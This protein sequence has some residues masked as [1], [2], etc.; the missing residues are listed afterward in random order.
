[1][2]HR[3]FVVVIDALGVGALPDT[4]VYGDRLTDNTLATLDAQAENFSI[5]LLAQLGLGH[6]QPFQRIPAA[7]HPI[8]QYGKLAEQSLGKD[9]TTGHWEMMGHITRI[10]FPTYPNGFPPEIID[11]FIAQTGCTNVLGNIPASGTAILYAFL[12]EIG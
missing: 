12:I 3:V 10:P 9:T 5:P 6:L 2:Q 1:M 11:P 7:A 4:P 8:G